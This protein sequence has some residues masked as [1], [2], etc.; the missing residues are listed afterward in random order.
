MNGIS[1]EELLAVY[2]IQGTLE[3]TA[4]TVGMTREG[5]RYRLK[6]MGVDTSNPER[7]SEKPT[8]CVPPKDCELCGEVFYPK[9]SLSAFRRQR[10]CSVLCRGRATRAERHSYSDAALLEAVKELRH[11]VKIAQHFGVTR[12]AV[13]SRLGA[14]YFDALLAEGES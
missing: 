3:A 4:N 10:F 13:M 1:D 11:P 9:D 8:L 14:I 7:Y 5:V 2:R 6:G 12:S